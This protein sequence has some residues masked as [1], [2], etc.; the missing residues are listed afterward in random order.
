MTV[1]MCYRADACWLSPFCFARPPAAGYGQPLD[2]SS[3]SLLARVMLAIN[4]QK[5]SWDDKIVRAPHPIPP[6]AP[7]PCLHRARGAHRESLGVVA[8][9]A[10]DGPPGSIHHRATSDGIQPTP[11]LPSP[12]CRIHAAHVYA[13]S[14][15]ER[16]SGV[17]V[18]VVI[19]DPN[20][21]C[22]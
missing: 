18:P 9:P 16:G 1:H 12:P 3:F 2:K 11:P 22:W 21:P 17:Q 20:D 8:A 14:H 19:I 10:G 13:V 15:C 6:T 5:L 7:S 4:W